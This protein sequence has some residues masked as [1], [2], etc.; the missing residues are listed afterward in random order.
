M[1]LLNEA[2]ASSTRE[3]GMHAPEER[4][5]AQEVFPLQAKTI[6]SVAWKVARDMSLRIRIRRRI[7]AV[8]TRMYGVCNWQV[9]APKGNRG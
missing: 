9:T 4:V 7:L 2:L 6:C 5:T 8:F 3:L 1:A